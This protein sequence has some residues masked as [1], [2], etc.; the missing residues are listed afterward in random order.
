MS[1]PPPNDADP[2]LRL[3]KIVACLRGP[4]GC[5]WDI[6]QTHASLRAHMVEEAYEVIDAIDRADD[7]HLR[8]ELG[9]FLLQVFMHSRIAEERGAFDLDAVTNEVCEKLVRRHP[10]V[11]G[12]NELSDSDAV[13]KQWEE[14]KRGEKGARPESVLDGVPASFPALLRAEKVQ[15]KAAR[16]GFDWPDFRGVLEKIREETVEVEEALASGDREEL[17]RE[18]GDLFFS[19]VNLSRKC[20]IDAELALQRATSKFVTRFRSLEA[21]L[22]RTGKKFAEM[23]L[24]ELDAIWDRVKKAEAKPSA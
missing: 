20:K 16:V 13:L 8:E 12:G 5:P 19:V 23:T 22:A 1:V 18:I 9:D 3:R 21:E 6:E 15:K 14:I 24:P 2:M 10:H 4:G 7:P 11:F 17:E